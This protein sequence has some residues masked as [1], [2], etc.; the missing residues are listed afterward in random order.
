[1]QQSGGWQWPLQGSIGRATS[2][3]KY[4]LLIH[5]CSKSCS[6]GGTVGQLAVRNLIGKSP[7]GAGFSALKL[8]LR[9]LYVCGKNTDGLFS[10]KKKNRRKD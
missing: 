6:S 8:L 10:E 9:D 1:M 7:V 4:K 5:F 3:L 2:C